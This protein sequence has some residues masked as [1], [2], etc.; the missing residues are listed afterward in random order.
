[1]ISTIISPKGFDAGTSFVDG[2]PTLSKVIEFAEGVGVAAASCGLLLFE[3]L[4]SKYFVAPSISVG[5]CCRM[6]KPLI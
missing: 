5:T 2:E 1:M 6:L 3:A 4:P